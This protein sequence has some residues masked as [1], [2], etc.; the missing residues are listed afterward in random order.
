MRRTW[1]SS[2]AVMML[3]AGLA[4]PLLAKEKAPAK[5]EAP[6]AEV[7]HEAKAEPKHQSKPAHAAEVG[8]PAP[9]FSLKDQDGKEVKLADL[10]GKIVVLEWTNDG[11][12]VW[13]S[14]HAAGKNTMVDLANSYAG[15][16]VVWLG[17]D[18]TAGHNS[19]HL[20][21]TVKEYSL[22]Y[23]VLDDTAGHAGKA[24]GA[25]TTPHMFVIDAQG[26]LAYAGAIDDQKAGGTNY[27]KAAVDALLAGKTPEVTL[28]KPYGCGVKYAK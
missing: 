2:A 15:K 19:K 16:D 27:V 20:A 3:A 14:H 18:S 8:Q 12:P 26:K 24:Y 17:V 6:K 11:C 25:R 28:T 1:M 22:P 4:Q 23:R 9:D 13:K 21:G 10:K 7:K 5:A